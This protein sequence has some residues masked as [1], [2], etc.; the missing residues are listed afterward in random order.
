MSIG[1]HEDLE[2]RLRVAYQRVTAT[3]RPEGIRPFVLPQPVR[4]DR[5]LIA[6]APAAA[7]LAVVAVIAGAVTL[8]RLFTATRPVTSGQ[9]GQRFTLVLAESSQSGPQLLLEVAGTSRVSDVIP[10]PTGTVWAAVASAGNGTTFVAA[11][12]DS[13]ACTSRLYYITPPQ[14]GRPTDLT[15]VPVPVIAGVINYPDALAV[16]ADGR[17]IAYTGR[18]TPMG[19]ACRQGSAVLIVSVVGGPTRKRTLGSWVFPTDL[20][21]S[22]DGSLLSYGV[23]DDGLWLQ[24]TGHGPGTILPAGRHLMA[25]TGSIWAATGVLSASGKTIYI[26]T[27]RPGNYSKTTNTLS[28][29]RTADGAKLRTVHAWPASMMSPRSPTITGNQLEYLPFEP[30]DTGYRVDLGSGRATSFPVFAPP[31]YSAIAVGW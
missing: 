15:P 26:I 5:R 22:A 31:G 11:A 30:P 12:A 4:R 28:E 13:R 23:V 18:A 20:S 10:A 3:V 19:Q 21:L 9:A 16:S 6:F 17:T 25:D 14:A 27:F 2:A 1:Q 24:P 29:Y 7:A 8:P